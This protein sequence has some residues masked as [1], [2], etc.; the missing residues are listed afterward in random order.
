M[1]CGEKLD[2]RTDLYVVA[3]DDSTDIGGNE[4]PIGERAGADVRL[5][6]VVAAKRREN[7]GVVPN[8]PQ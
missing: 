5:V 3:D 7:D 4:S 2:I 6:A 8:G 1:R